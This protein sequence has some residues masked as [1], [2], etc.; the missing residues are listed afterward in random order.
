MGIK[1]ANGKGT[2]TEDRKGKTKGKGKEK[3][4]GKENGIDYQI[5]REMISLVL[6]LCS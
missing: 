3:G 6:L 5:P 4:N 1:H 2:A